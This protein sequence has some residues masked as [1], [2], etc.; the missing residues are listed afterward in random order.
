VERSGQ[1]REGGEGQ[2]EAEEV[3]FVDFPSRQESAPVPLPSGSQKKEES[4]EREEA[5][6]PIA[7]AQNE[8]FA[9]RLQGEK[10]MRTELGLE[11]P[12]WSDETDE[13][14]EAAEETQR[15]W[16]QNVEEDDINRVAPIRP[17]PLCPVTHLILPMHSTSSSAESPCRKSPVLTSYRGPHLLLL[18]WGAP[19][20]DTL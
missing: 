16:Q 12:E 17:S 7:T 3:D 5:A 9:R 20:S 11:K 15:E 8:D 1:Q 2:E 19:V 13:E 6:L 4:E 14:E 18:G 10:R